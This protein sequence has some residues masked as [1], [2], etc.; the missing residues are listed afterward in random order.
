MA[1]TRPSSA[2]I[3]FV[4][5]GEL[6]HADATRSRSQG[7]AG[8]I[9]GLPGE[10]K[11]WVRVGQRRGSE[12]EHR[13]EAAPGSDIVVLEFDGGPP[14]VLHPETARD[15]ML[16]QSGQPN[17]SSRGRSEGDTAVIVPVPAE[18]GWD[19]LEEARG[20]ARGRTRGL[21]GKVVLKAIRILTRKLAKDAPD[22]VVDKVIEKV[23]G[24]VSEG[25]Y[26]LEANT[27]PEHLKGR[28]TVDTLDLQPRTQ[29]ALV[30]IHGTF[31]STSGTFAKLWE[32]HP[33]QV[34]AL[35][36]GFDDCV[37]ALDH[38]TLGRSPIDNALTLARTC[39]RGTR[40]HLLTHSRGG[41]V[42][43]VLARASALAR[44]DQASEALFQPRPAGEGETDGV[45]PKLFAAWMKAQRAALGELIS[46]LAER[47]VVVE[48]VVRVA[49]PA[50]GTLLASTR[51]DAY[52]SIFRWTLDLAKLP[53]L[54][55]LVEFLGEVARR[56][57]DPT[58]LPGLAAMVPDSP[59]VQ[60]LHSADHPVR[61]SLKVVAGDLE[62]TS[63]G[64]WLKTLMA[65]AFFW[66]DNDLV[67][68]TRSMYGGVPRQDAATFQAFQGGEVS[69]FTYFSNRDSA[70]ALVRGLVE[71]EP[72]GWRPIGPLSYAGASASGARAA[73]R[74]RAA[75]GTGQADK[76][77]VFVLP[78]ILG[79]HL[80]VDGDRVWLGF[81]LAFGL[82]KLEYADDEPA[83][84]VL[85]DGAV[86]RIYDRL[87]DFL[88]GTHE[89]VEFS[90][91]W[92]RPIEAEARRLAAAI[93][94]AL[95]ARSG[96][97]QP[98]RILAHSMG[99]LVARTVQ[100][101]C[102]GTWDRMMSVAGGRLLMLGTPNG[103]SWAPMQTL[104][105]D[106]TFGNTL[107]AFGAPFQDHKARTMMA[108]FPGF[109]QLQTG[110]V[111]EEGGLGRSATWQ[112]L[113]DDD[114]AAIRDRSWW[115][116]D[117]RQLVPYK[118]GIPAQAVLD[119]AM[120][121]RRRL[122]DQR[123]RA[124][125]GFADRM[126]LVTGRAEFTPDGYEWSDEGLVYLNAA[127][128]GD[129]RVTRQSAMLPG[130][131]TWH[132]PC[133]HGALPDHVDAF[134][135]YLE[136]LRTGNTTR[137]PVVEASRG[138]STV[139]RVRSR[140]SRALPFA[141]PLPPEDLRL[142]D[143]P[144][145]TAR[146]ADGEAP[147][148]VSIVNGD[149]TFVRE[150]LMLGHYTSTRLSGAEWVVDK[151]I[152]GTMKESLRLGQ[153]PDRTGT[154]QLFAN[155]GRNANPLQPP[156]PASV[157]VVG[158]GEE[159]KL[160][161]CD[162]AKTVKLGVLALAQRMMEA[163]SGPPAGFE[164]A[165]VLLGSGGSDVSAAKSAQ[166]VAQGVRA[167]DMA[168]AELARA[169]PG[170]TSRWPRV[171]SLKLI[172]LYLNRAS[173]AWDALALLARSSPQNFQLA[174]AIRSAPGALQRPLER[175]YR[176]SDYGFVRAISSQGSHGESTIEYTVHT[177]RAR[178][179]IRAQ[180][181]QLPLVQ[182]LVQ[183][184]ANDRNR[185]E[186][187]GRTLFRLLVPVEL[188]PLL[189]ESDEMLLELDQGTA[190][191]PW[192]VLD[193]PT[194]SS[195]GDSQPWAIRA[196][197]LRKLRLADFRSTV[198]DART[199]GDILI[200]G[201]PRCDARY[202]P[203]LPGARRE[204]EAVTRLFN[205]VPAG[206]LG[207]VVSLVGTGADEDRQTE[208]L[209]ILNALLDPDRDWR[210]IHV[211]GHGEPPCD[212]PD[213]NRRAHR[214]GVVLSNDAFL[215]PT[216]VGQLR[217]VPELV[218]VNCCHLAARPIGQLLDIGRAGMQDPARF[219]SGIA[220]ALIRLGVK[221]VIAA[222][223]AVDDDPAECFA[224]AF[225]RAILRG[226]R[227]MDAVA[228]ARSEARARGGNTWAA[229]QCY[230]DPDWVFR[231]AG[232]NPER[233]TA[234]PADEF[235][236]ITSAQALVLALGTLAVQSRFQGADGKRQAARLRYLQ[237]RF[238]GGLG[239]QGD[240]AE[241]FAEAWD[242]AGERDQAIGWYRRALTAIDG[243]ASM[244]AS[245]QLGNLLVRQA[246]KAV[247]L[248][249]RAHRSLSEQ[250]AR[251]GGRGPDGVT[252]QALR[253]AKRALDDAITS[254]HRTIDEG[255]SVLSKLAAMHPTLERKSLLGSAFKRRAMILRVE[256]KRAD[257][258]LGAMETFYA[259]AEAIGR[260]SGAANL[261]YP[262]TNCLAAAIALALAAGKP[263]A[264]D[265]ERVASLRQ[266]IAQHNEADPDFWSASA[267]I[268]LEAYEAIAA[269]RLAETLD[270]LLAAYKDLAVR[271]PDG[272]NW[273][274]V[275]DQA[276][277]VL[278]ELLVAGDPATAEAAA[279]RSL[280][281]ALEAWATGKA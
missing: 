112:K 228:E 8:P 75:D 134:E 109:L 277:F 212:K 113:Y 263:L 83:G 143:L 130:V 161:A 96:S 77:A 269:G 38:A 145:D 198:R 48:R 153:Y 220:E 57:F 10:L 164:L 16:A 4:V 218:F 244:R 271:V 227:F 32:Q 17:R 249:D 136:L 232:A 124:L 146:P 15:L 243:R 50:R 178:S 253:A 58:R 122:D 33:D 21:L 47:A 241:A 159:G 221:C 268:E 201:E 265:S 26:R 13:L 62:G 51:F 128:A 107:V 247:E 273:A 206:S 216:E 259:E 105:G 152:G 183:S 59:L 174:P 141:P 278:H 53:V 66:T 90:Y 217:D 87:M 264:L 29:R 72:P 181:A 35:F 205:E 187:F 194:G 135:A 131:R 257:E 5:S 95:D 173:E 255:M 42:A 110:L 98:V 52:L 88:E 39:P 224:S 276:T 186:R 262:G 78:G 188:E 166:F 93:D 25:V 115:H 168:L 20:S 184:A 142:L 49:C 267:A 167:A 71:D 155:T 272:H 215:G 126:L 248:A 150:P 147:L 171:A 239:R 111:D 157:L 41:L 223:W 100:L 85:P 172:E 196:K 6:G 203:P 162:I 91:D 19:G 254:A 63:V 7:D 64:S 28:R 84:H 44:P 179:E 207:H 116:A 237:S 3:T 197:L 231:R 36:A 182:A 236:N 31:S 245:E 200:I 137:L 192:E 242:A 226:A 92:R 275:R 121:L 240:V 158:L 76:P 154:H 27:L 133:E 56:R 238:E 165:A 65:D 69:H 229:Y 151:L 213:A 252:Q 132:L 225:Y 256:G 108:Q 246:W 270:R 73:R 30:L 61:G 34:T 211:A 189:G 23:D 117:F 234:P 170:G 40:L 103:G 89:V 70:E 81:R 37:Y 214:G 251:H 177:Q 191:I 1:S 279:A 82:T 193:T 202:Y 148:P 94:R 9:A 125:A 222:G 266:E 230:G 199:D 119:A 11:A 86:G 46:I 22:I 68:Q 210:I 169:T 180:S 129:G 55:D 261:F 149:L 280:V 281:A 235:A 12:D 144:V 120:S 99:G 80:K 190:G 14:L 250:R 2:A 233:R 195:G 127:E 102:P 176:G 97:G 45:D 67:V 140:P 219:A 156:R 209:P 60:W 24:Q 175:G 274:S 74:A 260:A 106:D 114:L 204:A 118:W 138:T 43:E 160:E 258:A 163:E 79:S 104:S 101:E 54:P 208:A 185:D 123:D 139:T 18:F